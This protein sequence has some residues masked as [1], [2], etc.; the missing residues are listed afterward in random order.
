VEAK[1]CG[2]QLEARSRRK[3]RDSLDVPECEHWQGFLHRLDIGDQTVRAGDA[4]CA[5][6]TSKTHKMSLEQWAAWLLKHWRQ[7]YADRPDPRKPSVSVTKAERVRILARRRRRGEGLFHPQDTLWKERVAELN[8]QPV[9]DLPENRPW[10]YLKSQ[11][12]PRS[13]K[14]RLAKSTGPRVYHHERTD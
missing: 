4:V 10:G 1:G 11:A 14:A 7:E 5:C 6:V 3:L 13:K 12:H 2:Q 8:G 9:A